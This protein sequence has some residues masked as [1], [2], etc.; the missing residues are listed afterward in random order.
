MKARALVLGVVVALACS[1][2]SLAGPQTTAP[3]NHVGVYVNVTDQ[4][5][6]MVMYLY[7]LVEGTPTSEVE[8]AA[9]RGQLA[10]FIVRNRGKKPHN[11]VVF[12]R[13]TRT[14]S[15]GGKAHFTVPLVHRGAFPYESTLDKGKAAFRGFF[16][17]Y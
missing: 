15:P 3:G 16:T 8:R 5:I 9:L 4:G 1:A 2:A 11:F 10:T 14:L 17:V 7:G 6:T 12:G 13:K